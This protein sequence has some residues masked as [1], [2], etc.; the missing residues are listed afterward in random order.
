MQVKEKKCKGTGKAIGSGCGVVTFYRTYG[1]GQSCGCY[2]NWLLNTPEGKEKLAAA[3]FTV[4]KPRIGLEKAF[5][6]KKDNQKLSYLITSTV[7]ACHKYIRLRDKGKPCVS[8]LGA[9]GDEHQAGHWKKAELFSSLKLDERNIHGQCKR[10]NLVEDGNVQIYG[11]RI[12][13]RIGIEGK[14][15]LERL[16]L[17]DKQTS[18]KWDREE[19]KRIRTYYNNK[20]KD[21]LI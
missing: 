9:W 3:T 5:K 7:N 19:L 2:S 10:C 20:T 4:S 13:L 17:L 6:E 16:A 11:T 21:L 12:H 1:L 15:E 18:F 14:Q 8:C